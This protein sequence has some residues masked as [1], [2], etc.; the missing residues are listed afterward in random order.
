MTD[1]KDLDVWRDLTDKEWQKE[2]EKYYYGY[3]VYQRVL[4]DFEIFYQKT[5][6]VYA[7]SLVVGTQRFQAN[8]VNPLRQVLKPP[9][10][11]GVEREDLERRVRQFL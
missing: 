10:H 9:N 2:V 5:V 1:R 3:E 6:V 7:R 4:K 11:V 8:T